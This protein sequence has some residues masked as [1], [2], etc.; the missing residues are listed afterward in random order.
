MRKVLIATPSYDGRVDVWYTNGLVNAIRLAQ[1][2]DIFLHPVFMSYDSLLQRARNDCIRLA[3]EGEYESMIFIDSDMEFNPEWILELINRPEDIVGGT[4]RKKTDTAEL[5]C[6]KTDNIEKSSNGLI[7]LKS[8]GTGFVKISQKALKAIW[9]VSEPYQNE[10]RECRM[11]CNVEVRNGQ[12]VSED[13]T[14]FE[15]LGDLGFDIWLDPKMCCGHIGVKKYEGNL[16]A[17]LMRLKSTMFLKPLQST[18]K[19]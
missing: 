17:Y 14:L 19:G 9:D 11:C 12:L 8:I 15:R 4:A 1:A 6:V 3:I 13:I 7:K 16:E 5:Y 18:V 10:G 2:S